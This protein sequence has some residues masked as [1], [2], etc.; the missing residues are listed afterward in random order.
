VA[1]NRGPISFARD[2]AGAVIARRGGGGLVTA[3]TGALAHS[4][5]LWVASAMSEEDRRQAATG[6]LDDAA[7]SGEYAVRYLVF[8]PAVYNGFYNGISNRVLWFLHHLLWDVPREPRF[9]APAFKAWRAYREVNETFAGVLDHEGAALRGDPAFLV[10]DYH[11]ALVPAMLR[12]RRSTARINHFSHIPF[13]GPSYLRILPDEIRGELLRGLLGADV[14]GFQ[15]EQWARNF[16]LGCRELAGASVDLRARR[17]RWEGRDV[18]VRVYPISIDADALVERSRQ[19]DVARARRRI[20]RW[21]GEGK[22][23]VRVDRGELSKNVLR[24]FLAYEAF[25]RGRPRWRRRVRFLA[26]LNPSRQDIPEYRAYLSECP[27]MADRINDRFGDEQ[28]QPVR[29][30][31]ED[32][33]AGSAAAM[34]LYDVLMVNPVFDG[35][36]LVAKEG[37]VLNQRDGVV[38]LSKNA[39]AYA[40]LR[41]HAI[42]VNPFDVE[43]TAS[44]IATGLE[45]DPAGRRRRAEG[46]R[47]AVLANPLP[48][49]VEAQ[50]ADLEA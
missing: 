35:M 4:G 38:I 16:L 7:G 15:A 49:W 6:R 31:I 3:L 40:E 46:L 10:Q 13:C 2:E 28:W 42:G 43:E 27:R 34:S 22:L 20:E 30:S 21:R 37:P 47:R 39:G 17:V 11:L 8:D 36:N 45:M 19:E 24:G 1:S 26:L 50:L 5:G 29:L 12:A 48:R 32:D 25:L 33:L 23:L 18:L 44:A 41:K 14:V 9:D